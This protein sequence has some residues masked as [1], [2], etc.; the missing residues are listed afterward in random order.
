M[1]LVLIGPPG[2]GKGTQAKKIAAKYGF[3]H[4]STGDLLREEIKNRTEIGKQISLGD[5][6]LVG[7]DVIIP[8]LTAKVKEIEDKKKSGTS[9]IRASGIV[10]DGFPRNI[11][12]AIELGKVT[13]IDKAI[14]I[15]VDDDEAVKRILKRGET[16]GRDDDNK[17]TAVKRLKDYTTKTYPIKQF[18]N[19][20]HVLNVV[21]GKGSIDDVF[22][23]ICKIIDK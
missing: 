8:L 11:D 21:N 17:E 20:S 3:T 10:F 14:L 18:Y 4:L 16:S 22:E 9:S 13:K 6:N 7:D 1:N 23:R 12:Q 5:G 2:S 15:M 19:L